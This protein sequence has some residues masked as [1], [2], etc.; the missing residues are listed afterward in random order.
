MT[1]KIDVVTRIREAMR[2]AC[3]YR[4]EVPYAGEEHRDRAVAVW[5]RHSDETCAA[6]AELIAA[7]REYDEANTA[8]FNSDRSLGSAE[9]RRRIAARFRRLHAL[10]RIAD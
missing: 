6:I 8:W 3:R 10:A 1:E 7:D 4:T 9:D 2:L 5:E